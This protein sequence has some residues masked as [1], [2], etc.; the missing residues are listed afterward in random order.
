MEVAVSKQVVLNLIRELLE[1][2]NEKDAPAVVVEPPVQELPVSQNPEIERG[3][4]FELPPVEDEA[5]EPDTPV[6][7]AQ[8]AYAVGK[9]VPSQDVHKFWKALDRLAADAETW[10]EDEEMSNSIVEEQLRRQIRQILRETGES[11]QTRKLTKAQRLDLIRKAAK[12]EKINKG[13]LAQAASDEKKRAA[14]MADQEGE[15]AAGDDDYLEP[16]E[17]EAEFASSSY[18]DVVGEQDPS[19]A[20]STSDDV[21]GID[22]FGERELAGWASPDPRFKTKKQRGEEERQARADREELQAAERDRVAAMTP[23]ERG[24]EA[25]WEELASIFQFKSPSGA[26]QMVDDPGRLM[27]KVRFLFGVDTSDPNALE[28]L[29]MSAVNAYADELLKIEAISDEDAA[30]LR[31]NPEH[32]A[33]LDSY[34]V[35]LKK[36]LKRAMR[37]NPEIQAHITGRKED[38]AAERA[39]RKKAKRDKKLGQFR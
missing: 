6:E 33:G 11:D 18:E 3:G 21:G 13:Y 37:K 20:P 24:R 30:Y 28:E 39:A 1:N 19:K 26:K 9:S 31:D 15:Y 22:Y 35:F 32:T 38:R 36:F 5:Y 16:G 2:N 14:H 27:D 34:R 10:Q 17:T 29:R 4:P 25:S 12:R 8:A 7:L 23:G